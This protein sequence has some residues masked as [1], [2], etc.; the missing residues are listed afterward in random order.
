M[1]VGF[2][3]RQ[4]LQGPQAQQLGGIVDDT[5]E[6]TRRFAESAAP[7]LVDALIRVRETS[8]A[9]ADH[10]RETLAAIVPNAAAALEDAGG[11][12]LRRAIDGSVR[13][14]LAELAES[15]EAAVAAAARASE[16][17]TQQMLTLAETTAQMEARI[18][19]ATAALLEH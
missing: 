7:Q 3:P 1:A 19:T 2:A 10:A 4:G 8:N 16:R 18:E 5:I 9:A 17:L 14:Q 15:T 6:T 13:R 11:A 12:A